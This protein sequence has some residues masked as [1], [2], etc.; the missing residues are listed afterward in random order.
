VTSEGTPDVELD[1]VDAVQREE[2]GVRDRDERPLVTLEVDAKH[3]WQRGQR[4]HP[5][6]VQ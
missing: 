4:F 1:D 5:C 3:A 6:R 2:V